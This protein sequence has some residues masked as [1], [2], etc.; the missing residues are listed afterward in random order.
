[1]L[2]C[3]CSKNELNDVLQVFDQRADMI[4]KPE[5]VVSHRINWQPKSQNIVELADELGLGLDSFVFLDDNPVEIAEV[6]ASVPEVTCIQVPAEGASRSYFIDHLW[7]LDHAK[8][9]A[10]DKKRTQLYRENTQRIQLERSSM[11]FAAFIAGLNLQIRIKSPDDASLAR[12]SQLTERTSQFNIN[13]IKRSPNEFAV[14][15]DGAT[16]AVRAVF[17]EDRFGDYGLVALMVARLSGSLVVVES[18]LM[19]CRVLGRG[20]EHAMIA[21]LGNIA[22]QWGARGIRISVHP[23][24]RNEPVRRFL[25]TL[26]A[27]MTIDGDVPAFALPQI[28]A[29]ALKFGAGTL[30]AT[31]T[32]ELEEIRKSDPGAFP[33]VTAKAWIDIAA[34]LNNVP[35]IEKEIRNSTPTQRGE[36]AKPYR[37]PESPEESLLAGLVAEVLNKARVSIDDDLF[38]LGLHSLAAVQLVARI[39]MEIGIKVPIRAVFEART[40][41]RLAG[42]IRAHG[43]DESFWALV[44]LQRGNGTKLP[45]FCF[46][47]SG[48]DAVCYMRLARTLGP[49][50]TIYGVQASG[51]GENEPL[52]QSVEEMAADYLKEIS[53]S[54]ASRPLSPPRLV[55]R[56]LARVRNCMPD[57]VAWRGSRRPGFHGRARP[58]IR[59]EWTGSHAA[60]VHR[61]DGKLFR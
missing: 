17:V 23:T 20:V 29:S 59:S 26:P 34:R 52:A 44:A 28:A 30:S 55:V 14:L 3:L 46:H 5:H 41:A 8:A 2:V 43:S 50:Y 1:M 25:Q 49:E 13:G 36:E 24:R 58:S 19:S 27:A 33:D 39:R 38:S 11:D 61:G 60:G 12:L 9:T 56:R 51:L 42:Y 21:E 6:Q 15:R 10:E 22:S 32:E 7:L 18:F 31:V 54:T 40:V 37:P 16:S 35:S 47:P 53:C 45:L 57:N 4:L 48:G